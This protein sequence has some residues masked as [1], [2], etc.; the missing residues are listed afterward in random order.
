MESV[1]QSARS[2]P[3]RSGRR[4]QF[5]YQSPIRRGPLLEEHKDGPFFIAAGFYRPH[6]PDIATK[7]YFE[8]YPLENISLPQEPPEHI[9]NIPPVALT[10][11]P[12][13]YGLGEEK[14]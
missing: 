5:H 6:V 10:T 7:K 1:H 8:L 13:N 3:G 4:N 14:L 2:R 12:L 9:T 11:R